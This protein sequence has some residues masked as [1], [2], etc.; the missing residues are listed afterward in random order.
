MRKALG[1]IKAADLVGATIGGPERNHRRA[2]HRRFLPQDRQEIHAGDAIEDTGQFI[3]ALETGR[4]DAITQDSSDLVG[5]RTQIKKPD[6]YVILPKRLSK[7]L[8]LSQE[9]ENWIEVPSLQKL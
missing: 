9:A 3:N 4:V 6:D 7:E 5:K 8:L 2:E 1:V